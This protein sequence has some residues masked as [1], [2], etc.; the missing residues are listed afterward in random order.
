MPFSI[1]R[2][3]RNSWMSI[4]KL[5]NGDIYS[6]DRF[7]SFTRFWNYMSEN[8]VFIKDGQTLEL[9]THP[10]GIYESEDELLFTTKWNNLKNYKLISYNEL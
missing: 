4:L 2:I 7:A 8:N 10:G 1:S 3:V 6:T 9:M 5:Q